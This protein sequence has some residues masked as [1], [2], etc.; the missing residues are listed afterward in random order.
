M[1]NFNNFYFETYSFDKNTLKAT[2]RYSFDEEEFF[3]EVLDFKSNKFFPRKD[4]NDEIIQNI[5]FH[6]HLA[7]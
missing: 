1:K 5:L 6:V 2:F 3:E 4:L 7:L